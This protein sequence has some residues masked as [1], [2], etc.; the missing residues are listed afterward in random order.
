MIKRIEEDPAKD[1]REQPEI[2]CLSP[3]KT[4]WGEHLARNLALAGMVVITIA[5][6]RGAELPSGTTVLTA[7]QRMID[8]EWEDHLGKI[9]FVGRFL[10]ET[11]A[12]FF[13]TAP[14]T[15]LIAPCL[16]SL[17][18]PWTEREPYLGYQ[19]EDQRVFATA[20]GQVMSVY[21]GPDEEYILRVRHEDGLETLYYNLASASVTEGDRVTPGACLG[22]ALSGGTIIEVRRAGRAIDPT[23]MMVS[24]EERTP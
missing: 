14:D 7:V 23:G 8:G 2:T 9:S 16:G 11:V 17:T 5:A 21:H 22:E 3:D 18:H 24:R 4:R 1:Q 13:E 19:G 12:V 15:E 20:A 10:P 6:V